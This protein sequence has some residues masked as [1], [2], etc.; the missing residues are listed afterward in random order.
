VAGAANVSG[1]GI[2][3]FVVGMN[4]DSDVFW[5]FDPLALGGIAAVAI[6]IAAAAGAGVVAAVAAGWAA[7]AW[8]WA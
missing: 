1:E 7:G 5:G 2:Q 4:G 3:R 8:V 6:T